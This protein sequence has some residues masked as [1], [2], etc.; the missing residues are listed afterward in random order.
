MKKLPR[1]VT[2]PVLMVM[3]LDGLFTLVGQPAG[4][5]NNPSLV[6]EGSPLGFSLL[7]HNPFFFILFF[8]IYLTVVYW[9]LKKLPI[10]I[11][12]PGAIAL[13]LGHVW[14]SSSWLSVLYRKFGF[15]IFDFYN[16]WLSISYFVVI[17]IITSL[18]ILRVDKLK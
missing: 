6:R 9:G 10:V 16:W 5:W 8:I 11:S 1:Q 7:L 15:E 2:I 3:I 12:L 18:F 13:F 4:Y 14:G 17:A